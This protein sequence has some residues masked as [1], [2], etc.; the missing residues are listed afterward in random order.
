VNESAG[1][2]QAGAVYD[3]VIAPLVR[4]LTALKGQS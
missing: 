1:R 3:L 4:L 2:E